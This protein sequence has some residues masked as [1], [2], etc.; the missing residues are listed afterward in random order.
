MKLLRNLLTASLLTFAALGSARAGNFDTYSVPVAGTAVRI[1]PPVTGIG[2][3]IWTS[4]VTYA[5]GRIVLSSNR[6]ANYMCLVPGSGASTVNPAISNRVAAITLTDGYRWVVV[7]GGGTAQ[8]RRGLIVA[9]VSGGTNVVYLS[10][11]SG[12]S[13]T[14]GMPLTQVGS[15]LASSDPF[16]WQD[17]VY[18]I[19]PGSTSL[20]SVTRW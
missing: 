18:A 13:A 11:G 16:C 15:N 14:A 3:S 1:C 5:Q 8:L 9:K 7:E 2:P 10:A 17:S 6:T 12:V 4:G 20:V 19:C